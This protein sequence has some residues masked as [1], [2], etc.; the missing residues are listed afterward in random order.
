LKAGWNLANR[1]FLK[2][3]LVL[4][5]SGIFI[6]I[7]G[8]LYRIPL[9]RLIGAE[10]MALY[11]K[12]Y[13]IY[14]IL[15]ALST[16]GFPLAISILVAE[17][18]AFGDYQGGRRILR[19]SLTILSGLALFFTIFLIFSA[20]WLAVDI[21]DDARVYYGLIAVSPAILLATV[22][23]CF[24]GYFQGNQT[25][26][27]TAISQTLE[28]IVR[29][30]T[31]LLLAYLLFPMGLEF[32]AAGAV[33]GAVTGSAAAV[34]VLLATYRKHKKTY[35]TKLNTFVQKQESVPL[36]LKRIAILAIPV[37]IGGLVTPIMQTIDA[38]LIPSRLQIAGY[39]KK[40][41]DEFFGQFSGMAN[42]LV[43]IAPIITLSISVA[44]IPIISEAMAKKDRRT[45]NYRINQA[46]WSTFLIGFP[47][48]AGLWVLA[49]PICDLLYKQPEV[50][51]LVAV[52]APSTLLFGLYQTTRATLQGMGKTYLPVVNLVAGIIVKGTLNY[53]LVAIPFLGINGAGIATFAA[54]TVAV[55]LN[56]HYIKKYT[57][58]IMDWKKN[59]TL[60]IVSTTIM[61]IITGLIYRLSLPLIGNGLAVMLAILAGVTSFSI[62]ILVTGGIKAQDLRTIPGIGA[63]LGDRLE[64]FKLLR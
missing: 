31:I 63:K 4:S 61:T 34:A 28:Q 52:L 33:F 60:P 35:A 13:P 51:P 9:A 32:S 26:N 11:Q 62:A 7:I 22:S 2:G 21:L 24:R 12:A 54:F 8:A 40:I 5:V 29:V 18:H 20:K 6:K 45:L 15:L 55:V 3:A 10:G 39:T 38:V 37:S 50:G 46:L 44:L 17:K 19:L 43:N 49:T 59:I 23:S 41:A 27:P 53:L 36:I 16:A 64:R 57:D 47:A 58:F 14:G 48:S 42:T 1:S 30:T 56:F 25:M